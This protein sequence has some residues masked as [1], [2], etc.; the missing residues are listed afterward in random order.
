MSNANTVP[1]RTPPARPPLRERINFRIILFI[2]II[3]GV[4]GY[5]IFLLVQG[6]L[7]HGIS[8]RGDHFAADLKQIGFFELN[9]Q[10]A[11]IN[12]VP[13]DYRALDGKRVSL[14]GF[15]YPTTQSGDRVSEWQLVYNIQKCCFNGPPKAQERVFAATRDGHFVDYSNG[16][17]RM[18]GTLHVEVRKDPAGNIASVYTMDV[19]KVEPL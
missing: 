15:M 14:E 9:P 11:T 7:T 12:D 17:I 3:L 5:P 10:T 8:K 4:L 1:Y 18:L 13:A 2:A 16:M 6:A 19:D